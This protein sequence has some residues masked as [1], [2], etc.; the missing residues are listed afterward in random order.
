[1][2]KLAEIATKIRAHL[3]R[4]EANPKINT[5]HNGLLRYYGAGAHVGGARVGIRYISFQGVTY[6][7]KA[8]ALR[9]LAWLDAG[10]VG[11]HFE[12]LRE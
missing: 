1:M 6:V 8:E 2:M 3:A 11:R 9:Y 4:F 10:N 7:S 5:K 12:A